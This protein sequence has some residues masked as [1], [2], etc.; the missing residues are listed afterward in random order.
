M[1]EGF[2]IRRGKL[3][4]IPKEWLHNITTRGTIKERKEKAVLVR[5]ARKRR[6]RQDREF[7]IAQQDY[8]RGSPICN[9]KCMA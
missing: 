2:R 5:S 4:E 7:D 3:V 6:L 8:E 9:S 1:T